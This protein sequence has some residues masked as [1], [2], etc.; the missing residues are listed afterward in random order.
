MT[1]T[2]T[3]TSDQPTPTLTPTEVITGR[4]ASSQAVNVRQGPG[5]IYDLEFVLRSGAQFTASG[6]NKDATWLKIR[7]EDGRSGWIASSLVRLDTSLP[8]PGYVLRNADWTPVEREFDGVPM[9]LVPAGCF[10]MGS[11]NGASDERPVHE[12]CILEPLWIDKTEVTQ[13][14]FRRFGGV[15]ARPSVFQGEDLPVENITWFEARDFCAL[16]GARLPSEAEWEYAARGPD[17]L[18]YPWGDT[19]ESPR[20]VFRQTAGGSTNEVGTLGSNASWVG[21]LDLIGNVW[22][23]T[24]SDYAPFPFSGMGVTP[25]INTSSSTLRVLR[26][27]S[28]TSPAENLNALRRFAPQAT[29]IYSNIG[30]RCVKDHESGESIDP[31]SADSSTV[32]SMVEA[33]SAFELPQNLPILINSVEIPG[34]V[35][36]PQSVNVRS[37]PGTNYGIIAVAQPGEI[38]TA[39]GISTTGDWVRIRVAAERVGWISSS[40]VE[41]D[42][43]FD[44]SGLI[45]RNLD[46]DPVIRDFGA[47]NMVL[48]PSGCFEMGTEG[49]EPA[50]R[51]THVVCI[52]KPYWLDQ[53]EVTQ[54][55]FESSGGIKAKP[56]YFTGSSNPVEQVTWFEARDYCLS[57]GAR[58]PSEAEWE[59]AARG[60]DGLTYPWGNEPTSDVASVLSEPRARTAAVGRYPDGASW[61]GA[62]DMSGNVWEWTSS[63]YAGYPYG[64]Q[65]ESEATSAD[66]QRVIRG[67]S[68]VYDPRDL[69]SVIRSRIGP[70]YWNKYLGFRCAR[71]YDGS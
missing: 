70:S 10:D 47:A 17:N 40:F 4:V 7:S 2:Q 15:Q 41:L 57:I 21:A 6:Q 11:E 34:R 69:R 46:W 66:L 50:L 54:A 19:F 22:E 9:M 44:D 13:E 53:T 55:Q 8:D 65:S 28:Y 16:R 36:S 1:P 20:V 67:G 64:S 56:N 18:A 58:L 38:V 52:E 60:P 12:Q 33:T 43:S 25:P 42:G 51:P 29:Y 32:E 39:V 24:E 23:W 68:W 37:G 45:L 3:A 30:V 49:A 63:V 71:D 5:T 62:L 61:V 48:V 59:F 27:G 26:G 35:I 14:Q 31:D